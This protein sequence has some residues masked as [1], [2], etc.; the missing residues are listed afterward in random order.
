MATK[1]GCTVRLIEVATKTGFTARLIEVA[2]KTGFTARLI[3]VATKTGFTSRLI[4][5]ATKTGFTVRDNTNTAFMPQN[6]VPRRS[7]IACKAN[8]T[9][10]V[11]ALGTHMRRY[12]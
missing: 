4:E 7:F 6:N 12:R 1:T 2:T 8:Q 10:I 9:D 11:E 5:V 3:E